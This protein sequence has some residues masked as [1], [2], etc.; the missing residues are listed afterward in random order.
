MHYAVGVGGIALML[1]VMTAILTVV[2][3]LARWNAAAD[4]SVR[5][6]DKP[7]PR[8]SVKTYFIL[9]LVLEMP[10]LD[11]MMIGVFAATGVF[12]F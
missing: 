12:L 4:G 10:V 6:A 8:R 9:L 5:P 1:I 11:T 7:P 3:V 2:V